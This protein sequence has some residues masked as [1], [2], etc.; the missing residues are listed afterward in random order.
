MENVKSSEHRLPRAEGR[1]V[2]KKKDKPVY[3]G[4]IVIYAILVVYTL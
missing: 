3:V 1:S 2:R 4:R